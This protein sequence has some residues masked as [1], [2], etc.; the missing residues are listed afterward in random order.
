MKENNLD[1]SIVAITGAAGRLGQHMVRVFGAHGATIAA[2]DRT[3]ARLA[4]DL[5]GDSFQVDVTDE[6][7]VADVFHQIGSVYGRLDVLVHTVGMWAS[8][9]FLETSLDDWEVL[10]RVNLTSTLLCFREAARLMQ[11][12]GG[13]LIGISAAQGVDCG[14]AQQAAYSASKGGVARLVESVAAEFAGSGIT[15]HVIAPSTIL[16]DE[17]TGG[18]GVHVSDLA[19]LAVYLCGA[20]GKALNG[21]TLRAYGQTLP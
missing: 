8:R 9:P 21:A 4:D 17:E 15:A 20:A 13:R 7:E 14:R 6:S 1:Q 12:H 11:E 19:D 3:P 16:F 18:K 2:I 5:R 10:M